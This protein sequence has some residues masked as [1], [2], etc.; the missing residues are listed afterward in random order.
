MSQAAEDIQVDRGQTARRLPL[1]GTILAAGA[2]VAPLV[3]VFSQRGIVPVVA[4]TALLS[5][6]SHFARGRS[7]PQWRAWLIPGLV[8]MFILWGAASALWSIEPAQSRGQSLQQL[9]WLLVL[10]LLV[11]VV[12]G[13]GAAERRQVA[14]AAAGGCLLAMALLA[15]DAGT[16]FGL[17][18]LIRSKG[19]PSHIQNK[20]LTSLVL[21]LWP[22]LLGLWLLGWRRSAM[23]LTVAAVVVVVPLESRTAALGLLA[24][25]VAAGA[26]ALG[27][28]PM[29][30]LMGVALAGVALAMPLISD[31]MVAGGWKD[32]AL[33][34]S[35]ARHRIII[36]EFV[37][38]RVRERPLLGWG[39]EVSR[40]IPNFGAV[41]PFGYKEMI[42]VH[43]HNAFMQVW[44]ELGVVGVVL[45]LGSVLAVLRSIVAM[46]RAPQAFAAG[47][48]AATAAASMPGYGNGQSWWLF[49]IM[50]QG[51][52]F[53]AIMR[54]PQRTGLP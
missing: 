27:G 37:A 46:P 24:G 34:D 51:L 11:P 42:P 40:V 7:L 32:T 25:I 38:E 9:G 33:L 19:V 5:S 44:L 1:P 30:I 20:A 4:V 17:Q 41:P 21:L 22:T 43:P 2:A 12:A 39:L 49:T 10:S 18:H 52:L 29:V 47:A 26:V 15:I 14:F 8:T 23:G 31:A 54:L 16:G 36:W 50:A 53:A 45:L 13:L 6:A 35:S 48:W 28:R 3:P